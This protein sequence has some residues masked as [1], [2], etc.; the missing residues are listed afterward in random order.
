MF[1]EFFIFY[2]FESGASF[3]GKP[4]YM[5]ASLACWYIIERDSSPRCAVALARFPSERLPFSGRRMMVTETKSK[6]STR[7]KHTFGKTTISGECPEV[8]ASW[9][10]IRFDWEYGEHGLKVVW[11]DPQSESDPPSLVRAAS[12]LAPFLTDCFPESCPDGFPVL[13]HLVF[14]IPHSFGQKLE[15]YVKLLPN[16]QRFSEFLAALTEAILP[17]NGQ[18]LRMPSF[19]L[20]FSVDVSACPDSEYV[21]EVK[22]QTKWKELFLAQGDTE[23]LSSSEAI[24][25]KFEKSA[26]ELIEAIKP[27][28]KS[29]LVDNPPDNYEARKQLV[30]RLNRLF[31]AA[32]VAISDPNT[33]HPTTLVVQRGA[34]GRTGSIRAVPTSGG[35]AKTISSFT[36]IEL[37]TFFRR[38]D[39]N[40]QHAK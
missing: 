17:L 32:G 7:Q 34:E 1:P 30:N 6:V 27:H 40:S 36:K 4:S 12:R 19:D 29:M 11:K 8:G 23:K 38:S 20:N 10:S 2:E 3:L 39:R 25:E 14:R 18:F 24:L 33:G 22:F 9:R 35:L 37:V 13:G 16:H 31:Q 28:L 26:A 5:A 15:S 21:L